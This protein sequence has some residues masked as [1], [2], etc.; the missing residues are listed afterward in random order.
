M[1][2][3]TP[4]GVEVHSL[5]SLGTSGHVAAATV[6]TESG[7]VFVGMERQGQEGGFEIDVARI[8]D[9]DGVGPTVEMASTFGISR[10]NG[11]FRRSLPLS[12][13]PWYHL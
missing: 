3:L 11:P 1:R 7:D 6:D 12:P 4:T 5:R 9:G 2:S 13:P 10:L 8:R